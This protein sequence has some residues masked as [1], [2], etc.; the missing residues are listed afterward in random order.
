MEAE[1]KKSR[2]FKM[3][4]IS[5]LAGLVTGE[6]LTS[7]LLGGGVPALLGR[8]GRRDEEEEMAAAK[9]APGMKRGGKVGSS[10]MKRGGNV[11]GDMPFFASKAK[12]K[13]ASK[14]KPARKPKT[15]Y[16]AGGSVR[17]DGMA[18]KGKT[19]GREC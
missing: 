15:N 5:P 17:G 4:D 16:K 10:C 6:G 11:D 12:D 7:G 3:G 14:K 2:G 13:M 1:G 8:L 9:K 19:R 18:T